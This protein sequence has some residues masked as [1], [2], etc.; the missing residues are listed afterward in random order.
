M[1]GNTHYLAGLA[2]ENSKYI[3]Y[4]HTRQ[5]SL[6]MAQQMMALKLA[7]WESYRNNRK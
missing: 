5:H 1:L 3:R 2:T 4:L 7:F 6:N